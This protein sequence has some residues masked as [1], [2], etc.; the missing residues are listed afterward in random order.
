M[1]D[2]LN[3]PPTLIV[4]YQKR[5]DTYS[6]KLAYVVYK[7]HKGKFRKRK[8]WEGWVD[9]KVGVDEFKNEPTSGFVLNRDA[10]GKRHSWSSWNTRVEKVRVYDP[11]DFE[12]EIDIPNL[13]FILQECSSL[14]GKGL[15][16]EFVYA[17]SG[18]NIILLPAECPE[19]VESMKFSEA[20]TKKVTAKQMT[21]GCMYKNKDMQNVIYLGRYE[22]FDSISIKSQQWTTT[23]N[24]QKMHIFVTED[25][26]NYWTQKGFTNLAEK[27]TDEPVDGF[28]DMLEKFLNSEHHAIIKEVKVLKDKRKFSW[29]KH[30]IYNNKKRGSAVVQI[31]EKVF[32]I[33]ILYPAQ[34]QDE[35]PRSSYWSRDAVCWTTSN[36]EKSISYNIDSEIV[37]PKQGLPYYKYMSRSSHNNKEYYKH[38]TMEELKDMTVKVVVNF[39]NG[40]HLNITNRR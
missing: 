11:R 9:K 26:K 6:G 19:Y 40:K 25:G 34:V 28:S 13:L 18:S 4:G 31:G 5:S 16:G 17:W 12:I 21:P 29:N 1:H 3:I 15:E 32:E 23:R 24:G 30:R 35:R 7:D 33:S 39:E 8:S 36:D 10:G 2:K 14:K 38:I 27:L 37:I 22:W 20:K